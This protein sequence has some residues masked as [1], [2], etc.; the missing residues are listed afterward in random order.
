MKKMMVMVMTLVLAAGMT[1]CGSIGAAAQNG[2]AQTEQFT[3]NEASEAASEM[4]E[5]GWE[6]PGNTDISKHPEAKAALEKAVSV[7]TG[8]E[9]EP[10]S[11]LATQVVAGTNYCILCK[12]TAVVP[13][14]LPVYDLVYVYE[15]LEGNA[16]IISIR[17]I[18]ISADEVS[19][20]H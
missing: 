14:A 20:D 1:A 2:T 19:T 4:L 7:M 8:A 10:V 3:E 12:V 16:D 18:E 15:D 17:E 6:A 11:L 9:Y 5:G 13:D